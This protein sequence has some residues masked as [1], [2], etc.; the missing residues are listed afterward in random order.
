MTK[1]RPRVCMHFLLEGF[2][3]VIVEVNNPVIIRDN[4]KT[5]TILPAGNYT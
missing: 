2:M 4:R 3:Y 5:I 1:Y